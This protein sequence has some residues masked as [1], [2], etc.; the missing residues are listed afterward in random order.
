MNIS[1][2][3]DTQ[4]SVLL[5]ELRK[6]S[7]EAYLNLKTNMEMVYQKLAVQ[8]M[9]EYFLKRPD[10]AHSVFQV[11]NPT[12]DILSWY[13]HIPCQGSVE[14][15]FVVNPARNCAA[16]YHLNSEGHTIIR[17]HLYEKERIRGVLEVFGDHMVQLW[18]DDP[19]DFDAPNYDLPVDDSAVV[20]F[21]AICEE[22]EGNDFL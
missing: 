15:Y 12:R 2:L 9:E 19:D 17:G 18:T 20:D 3:T 5:E 14:S 22:V 11:P 10:D 4:L 6:N 21:P 7:L 16:L 8:T 1:P 13:L